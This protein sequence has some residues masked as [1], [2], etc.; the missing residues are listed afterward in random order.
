MEQCAACIS[1][2]TSAELV[3]IN[4][5]TAILWFH[6]LREIIAD[7][8]AAEAPCLAGGIEVDESDFGGIRKGKPGRGVGSKVK[9]GRREKPH[10][11]GREC[12]EPGKAAN[13]PL[14]RQP[15]SPCLF[16]FQKM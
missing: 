15:E 4:R 7:Q 10:Q 16:V 1:A 14:Q 9:I 11:R 13:A 3:G 2:Q 6:K 5:N 8:M 12:L